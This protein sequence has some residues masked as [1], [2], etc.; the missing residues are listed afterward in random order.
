MPLQPGYGETPLSGDELDALLAHVV[1]TLGPPVSKADI[2]DLESAIL[3][4]VAEGLI[5][6]V[7]NGDLTL[8]ELLT[9]QFLRDLH[10]QLY[11][12]IWTW[13]GRWRS[14]EI[15]LGVA[16]EQIAV[17]LRTTMDNIRYRWGNTKDWTARELGIAA[18]A[19]G[20]RVHPFTDGNGRATRLHADLVFIAAQDSP[21]HQ[22][23][24]DVDRRRYIKLLRDFDRG[25]D[26]TDL[27]QI[28]R[29]V[30][31]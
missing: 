18:H 7:F 23:D 5:T 9:D 19:E 20:V 22:Y 24:W 10:R 15:N 26:V 6:D 3:Q 12:D 13:A 1:D 28:F 21:T 8:D 2:F 16:P 25:R 27:A 4:D 29:G 11:G 14:P 30:S 31:V 17:D